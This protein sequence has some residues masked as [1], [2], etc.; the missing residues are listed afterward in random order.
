MDT[1]MC[2]PHPTRPRRAARSLSRR[3]LLQQTS[4][5]AAAGLFAGGVRTT[6]A[7]TPAETPAA[8]PSGIDGE[9]QPADAFRAVLDATERYPLVGLGE[10]HMLQ[11]F[12]DFLAALLLNPG[13]PDKVDD[14]VVEFGNALYQE[15]ADRFLLELEPVAA[16]DLAQ[17]WRNTIGG[18]VYW[19][20]PVYE[21]FFRAVRAVNWRLAPERRVR[22]LLGDPAIDFSQIQGAADRGK[23]PTEA[24]RDPFF[25]GVVEREVLAKGRRALLVAGGAHMKRGL[26]PTDD[27]SQP[28]LATLLA[29]Q[30]PGSLFVVEALPLNGGWA[31]DSVRWRVEEEATAWPRPSLA[32]LAGTWLA[33]QP[34]PR[35]AFDPA[36]TYGAQVD[37]VLWLGSAAALTVSQA[38]PAIYQAGDYAAELRRRSEVLSEI[39]RYPDG[40]PDFIAEGLRL[41]TADPGWPDVPAPAATDG[42]TGS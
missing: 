18:R 32:L 10:R 8:T 17:I 41:A 33:D 6:S 5:L 22:V 14:V 30:H 36:S 38:D 42:W 4:A 20:A 12:H 37:A 29:E 13:F 31:P 15:I 40:P 16:A 1:F 35:R 9:L 25:A 27:P 7:E 21:R 26:H 19:D 34:M 24:S 3:R 28:N 11:E 23:V 39:G 2:I